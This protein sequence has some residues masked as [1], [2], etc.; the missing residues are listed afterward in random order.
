MPVNRKGPSSSTPGAAAGFAAEGARQHRR[1]NKN[2]SSIPL[3]LSRSRRRPHVTLTHHE[4]VTENA[5]NSVNLNSISR[6]LMLLTPR[7]VSIRNS[8][9]N[10]VPAI[11]YRRGGRE[12]RLHARPHSARRRRAAHS[13]DDRSPPLQ[14]EGGD[15]VYKQS[16]KR[17]GERESP[18]KTG[19][20]LEVG[21]RRRRRATQT[22]PR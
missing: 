8:V 12:G 18:A 15:N 10:C 6:Q 14:D 21:A 16:L 9:G 17:S 11:R 5:K 22:S 4:H 1:S 19:V 13:I 2:T 7:G 20:D 3:S